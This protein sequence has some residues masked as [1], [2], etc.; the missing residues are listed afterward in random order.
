MLP[1]TVENR[2]LRYHARNNVLTLIFLEPIPAT[3]S[4]Y[5]LYKYGHF[6]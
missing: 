6:R 3:V 1:E 5:Q 2:R 4:Y